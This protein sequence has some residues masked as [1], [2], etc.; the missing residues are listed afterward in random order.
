MKNLKM[1]VM[2][3][4]TAES[5]RRTWL[6]LRKVLP[7]DSV[8]KIEA[9]LFMIVRFIYFRSTSELAKGR[10]TYPFFLNARYRNG[11]RKIST[12]NTVKWR[13]VRTLP[14]SE[15]ETYIGENVRFLLI[16]C[17]ECIFWRKKA[18]LDAVPLRRRGDLR[19]KIHARWT[20]CVATSPKVCVS[21]VSYLT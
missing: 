15:M 3:Y 19:H 6:L 7:S 14:P 5:P 12:H 11:T 21:A 10:C 16:L 8:M 9:V 4:F 1:S 2:G 20:R 17:A 13:T 18:I